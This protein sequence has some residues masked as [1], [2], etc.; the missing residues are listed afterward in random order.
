VQYRLSALDD[1]PTLTRLNQ[2]LIED[3]DHRN[4]FA[5][6][7]ALEKRMRGFLTDK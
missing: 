2:Q 5:L 1:L 3:E 6:Y 4:R 7:T